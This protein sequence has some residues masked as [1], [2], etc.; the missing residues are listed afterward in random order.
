M[1]T[2]DYLNVVSL[3]IVCVMVIICVMSCVKLAKIFVVPECMVVSRIDDEPYVVREDMKINRM[4][5]TF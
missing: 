1:S 2:K 3:L 4:L 5:L